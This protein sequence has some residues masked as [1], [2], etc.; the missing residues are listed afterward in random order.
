MLKQ[1]LHVSLI[2][3]PVSGLRSPR[4]DH[5]MAQANGV[6]PDG[7]FASSA[8]PGKL[9]I[10]TDPGIGELLPQFSFRFLLFSVQCA[11]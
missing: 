6:V 9:I 10:D 4:I 5:G 8:K 7:L 3:V 1:F 2:L 11:Y